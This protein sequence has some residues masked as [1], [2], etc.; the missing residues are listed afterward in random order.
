MKKLLLLSLA[1]VLFS[2]CTL[3][4]CIKSHKEEGKCVS[5]TYIHTGKSTIMIPHHYDCMKNICDEYEK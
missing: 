2:G 4:K 1:I 5:F 3:K